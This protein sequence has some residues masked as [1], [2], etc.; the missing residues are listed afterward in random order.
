MGVWNESVRQP[1]SASSPLIRWRLGCYSK[2]AFISIFDEAEVPMDTTGSVDVT[3]TAPEQV[4]MDKLI[5]DLRTVIA[6]TE[7]LLK[8]TANQAGTRI[9]EARVKLEESL[10]VAKARITEAQEAAFARTKTAARATDLYVRANPW[11][12]VGIAAGVGF[13]L[14]VLITRR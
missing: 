13:V 11:N 7:E 9:A 3:G 4:T 6:D 1:L 2:T 12:A 8:A 10:T 5:E 14:G